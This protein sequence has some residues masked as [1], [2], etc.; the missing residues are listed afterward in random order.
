MQYD[1]RVPR[2]ETRGE[3]PRR[4]DDADRHVRGGAPSLPD[5]VAGDRARRCD[6]PVVQVNLTG[7]VGNKSKM[8]GGGGLGFP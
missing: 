4:S 6:E 7:A 3:G 1:E 8:G 2:E 5:R